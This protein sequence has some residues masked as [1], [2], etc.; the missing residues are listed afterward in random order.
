MI[1]VIYLVS[2]LKQSGPINQALNLLSGYD[3]QQI[4]ALLVTLYVEEGKSWEHRFEEK[5][6]EI[7]CLNSD[8]KFFSKAAH[9]LDQIINERGVQVVHSSGL[10][11]D[12][13]NAML[14]SSVL[15]VTT[16]RS[17]IGDIGESKSAIVRFYSRWRFRRNLTKMDVLVG[18]SYALQKSTEKDLGVKCSCVQN[19]VDIDKYTPVLPLQK[20][21]L[22]D[23]LGIPQNKLIL[24]TVGV[25]YKRKQTI[26]LANTYLKANLPNTVLVI[27]GE[28]EEY[29]AL[30]EIAKERDNIMMVGRKDDPC[31]YYQCADVFLS[32]SLAEGLP[33]AVLEAMAC[34]LPVLLSDIEPHS[35]ILKEDSE[36]GALFKCGD[37]D[38]LISSFRELSNW[39]VSEKSRHALSV[40][41]SHF[42]KYITANNY[43]E[44]YK[45]NFR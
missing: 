1:N 14:K 20:R 33:N 4:N 7:I 9:K 10:S 30:K 19:G 38:K 40:I 27:V 29:D 23:L 15:K 8:H 28:G 16:I 22:R 34:G 35:E 43:V 45:Q 17:H 5:A 32:A 12:T 2:R 18:C 11:A 26:F 13:V 31:E 39:S 25:L 37:S 36:A 21:K 3:K 42:S 6:I 41:N 44:L 24:L